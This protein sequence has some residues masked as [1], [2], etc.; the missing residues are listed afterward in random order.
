MSG[1]WQDSTHPTGTAASQALR[2][3][4]LARDPVCRCPGCRECTPTGCEQAS[5]DDDHV[6]PLSLGGS[7]A[8]ANHQGMCNPCHKVK[9]GREAAA[10]KARRRGVLRRPA[11]RHPGLA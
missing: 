6:V 2:R 3:R 9:T 7:D 5:T 11:E 8:E 1:R 4:I 10:A